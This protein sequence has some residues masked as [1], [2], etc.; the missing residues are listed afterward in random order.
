MDLRVVKYASR[1]S[2]IGDFSGPSWAPGA[3]FRSVLASRASEGQ[4]GGSAQG[5]NR[6]GSAMVVDQANPRG[7]GL[8]LRQRSTRV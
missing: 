3:I 6:M 1:R 5:L 8:F 7:Q 2:R 4:G